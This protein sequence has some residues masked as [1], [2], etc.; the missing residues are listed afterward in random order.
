MLMK[1]NPERRTFELFAAATAAAEAH[2]PFVCIVNVF[3]QFWQAVE[4][5]FPHPAAQAWHPGMLETNVPAHKT[6]TVGE[7]WNQQLASGAPVT[8]VPFADKYNVVEPQ[9]FDVQTAPAT[10]A[11]TTPA[12]ESV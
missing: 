8:H 4:L 5:Q 12:D 10:H 2:E 6:Q 7:A 9:L 11:E 3:E 1:A